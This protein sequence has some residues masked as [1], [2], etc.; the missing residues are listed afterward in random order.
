MSVRR[1]SGGKIKAKSTCKS[2]PAVSFNGNFLKRLAQAAKKMEP[3]KE[4]TL[5]EIE[6]LLRD[7]GNKT[8]R[9]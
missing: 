4:Y 6:R 2:E 7:S 3:D 8:E 1:V 9:G 5:T